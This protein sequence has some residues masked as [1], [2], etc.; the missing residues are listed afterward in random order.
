[1]T[2]PG[3]S[4]SAESAES[5]GTQAAKKIAVKTDRDVE[6]KKRMD[7]LMLLLWKLVLSNAMS[8]RI[9]RSILIMF[10]P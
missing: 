6:E 9:L 3:M 10:A 5:A 4:A 1:M 2:M 8:C 7:E